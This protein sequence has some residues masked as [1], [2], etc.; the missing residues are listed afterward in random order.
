[1]NNEEY[2]RGWE[3]ILESLCK[4]YN[5]Y[6]AKSKPRICG[7]YGACEHCIHSYYE[8]GMLECKKDY[9]VEKYDEDEIEDATMLETNKYC[10][11][12]EIESCKED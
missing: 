2:M 6:P 11:Y 4:Q 1:M 9:M 3:I 5:V 12:Y 10:P 7:G 8:Y